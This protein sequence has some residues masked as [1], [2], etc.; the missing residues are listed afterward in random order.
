MKETD[1]YNVHV[2]EMLFDFCKDKKIPMREIGRAFGSEGSTI[3]YHHKRPILNTGIILKYSMFFKHNFFLDI[4]A[5]LPKDFTTNAPK[6][7]EELAL[8]ASLQQELKK[9]KGELNEVKDEFKI[10]K[11]ERDLLKEIMGKS[12]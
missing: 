6:D 7:Q 11:A 1:Q 12:R 10:V 9:L 8:I 3:S 5:K 2:G 4:G